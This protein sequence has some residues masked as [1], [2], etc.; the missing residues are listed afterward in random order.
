MSRVDATRTVLVVEDEALV[1]MLAVD[2]FNG[3]GFQVVEAADAEEALEFLGALSAVHLLF[4][5][6]NMPG[7]I[8]GL[9]LA[10]RVAA[11]WPHVG[12]II[13]SGRGIPDPDALPAGSRFHTKPYDP[14]R[15]LDQAGELTRQRA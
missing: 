10:H 6:I 9:T 5:D 11:E 12:I 15:L 13:A 8:D 1:R 4:T 3:A 2:I 7:A 14:A